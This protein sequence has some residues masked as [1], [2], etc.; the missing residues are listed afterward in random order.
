MRIK[1]FLLIKLSHYFPDFTGVNPS[2]EDKKIQ[3]EGDSCPRLVRF[4]ALIF[5]DFVLV[6]TKKI[7]WEFFVFVDFK[8]F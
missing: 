2:Q 1:T 8:E 5:V 7:D 4:Q 6:A 3:S